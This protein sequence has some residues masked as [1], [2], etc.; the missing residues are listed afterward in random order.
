MTPI[1]FT[2]IYQQRVWG[3][4]KLET[5]YQRQLPDTDQP[6]GESWEISDRSEAQSIVTSSNFEGQTLHELWKNHRKELFGGYH[7]ERFPLL[8]KILDA[9]TDLSIQVHPPQHLASALNGK[10]KTEMWYIAHAEP[11]AAIYFGFKQ[12]TT[13]EDFEAALKN[14]DPEKFVHTIYPKAGD[15]I[16]IPSG[17]LHAIGAGIVIYEIQQNSDTTYRVFDWNRLGLD[18][19][20]R[21]LHIEE[22][23]K[24]IDFDD[25]EP[26]MDNPDGSTLAECP[27]YKV[28]HFK[29]QSGDTIAN[30]EPEKFSILTIIEGSLVDCENSTYSAG[31]FVILPVGATAL[32]ATCDAKVLQTTVP[33]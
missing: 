20:P 27:Y 13:K 21:E 18:G 24:C 2:P 7:S 16:H 3:G 4:R 17:R 30:P 5:I 1:T 8:V 22:S 10:P 26:E 29:L 11:N 15:S 12:G 23:M 19:K 28:D 9:Q 33:N 31:D 25:I 14:G 6:Y 32:S